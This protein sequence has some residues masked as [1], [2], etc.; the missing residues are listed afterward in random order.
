M[1]S[2]RIHLLAFFHA[3]RSRIVRALLDFVVLGNVV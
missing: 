3:R 1:A 2:V